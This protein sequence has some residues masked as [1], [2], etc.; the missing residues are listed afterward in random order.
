MR[1]LTQFS[2]GHYLKRRGG[3]PFS[4]NME[5]SGADEVR[6]RSDILFAVQEALKAVGMILVAGK[7]R[8]GK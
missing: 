6:V 2:G 8:P 7:R 3:R 5:G 4:R 1:S